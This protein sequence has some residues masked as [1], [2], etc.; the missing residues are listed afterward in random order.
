MILGI[1]LGISS[2]K[3]QAIDESN[4]ILE[5]STFMILKKERKSISESRVVVIYI[6]HDKFRAVNTK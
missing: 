4:S 6:N 5:K 2:K 1:G 3:L